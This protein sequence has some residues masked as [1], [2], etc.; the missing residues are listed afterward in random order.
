MEILVLARAPDRETGLAFMEAAGVVQEVVLPNGETARVPAVQA[1]IST[2]DDG[3]MP[4][5]WEDAEATTE[6]GVP[7]ISPAGFVPPPARQFVPRSG[8]FVNVKYYGETA[9]ALCEGGDPTSPDLFERSPGLLLLSEMRTGKP[10]TWTAL[11]SDP[12]PPGYENEDGVRLFDPAFIV[13]P[14][15]VIA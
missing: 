5:R 14:A 2:S 7:V 8:W 6:S 13:T 3:W 4:G 9:A 1:V 12:H 10:M 15:N 11:S